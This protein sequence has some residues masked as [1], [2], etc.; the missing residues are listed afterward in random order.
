VQQSAVRT[1][2]RI[3]RYSWMALAASALL[4]VISALI[5]TMPPISWFWNPVY[6]SAYSIMGAWGVTWV[7]FNVLA[8]I[9]TLIP[10]RRHERWAWFTLWTLPL[11]WL[12][13]FAFSPDPPYLMLAVLTVVG[14]VLPYRGFFSGTE[15]PARVK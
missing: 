10:Y 11:L 14:L 2:S 8:L 1:E 13:Q 12:S 6:E 5:T 9:V 15:E 4:G 3:E 7:G